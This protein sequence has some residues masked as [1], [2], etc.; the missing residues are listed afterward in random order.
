MNRKVG[1]ADDG[2]IA[3]IQAFKQQHP[4]L[5]VYAVD[6]TFPPDQVSIG[7][8]R[9][10]ACDLEL[11]RSSQRQSGHHELIL[12]SNDADADRIS[13]VYLDTINHTF[14]KNRGADIVVGKYDLGPDAL[15]KYPNFHVVQRLVMYM[16]KELRRL[17]P[18]RVR[19]VGANTAIR[20][21]MYAAIGGYNPLSPK[22]ED[23]QI[24]EMTRAARSGTK[25]RPVVF[26][27]ASEIIT[28]PRRPV[29]KYIHGI[30]VMD[31][32]ADFVSNTKIRSTDWRTLARKGREQLSKEW[33]EREANVLYK[34]WLKPRASDFGEKAIEEAL[35]RTMRHLGI[36]YS[37]A[38]DRITITNMRRIEQSLRVY[39][40]K[41]K[42]VEKAKQRPH[43]GRA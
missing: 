32:Y 11:L 2:T 1:E 9:K 41:R 14:E 29:T 19:T 33:I 18:V 37:L 6:K 12:V 35:A 22:A 38:H 40:K 4:E 31:E 25:R 30:S 24:G 16:E 43:A 5:R 34:N 21:S 36:E 42:R 3:T 10:Y 15:E 27:N 8:F 13:P 7:R 17:D 26:S 28:N 20:A 23:L 39:P